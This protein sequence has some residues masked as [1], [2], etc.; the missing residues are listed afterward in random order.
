MLLAV[1]GSRDDDDDGGD[2]GDDGRPR[3]V[4]NMTTRPPPAGRPRTA[5]PA[6]HEGPSGGSQRGAAT[7]QPATG[8]RPWRSSPPRTNERLP[9]PAK[10]LR[11]C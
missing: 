2:D 10:P 3:R 4:I 6:F 11:G 8:R 7:T 9:T 5:R 1:A